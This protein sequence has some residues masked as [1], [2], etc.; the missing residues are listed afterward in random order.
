M[1]KTRFFLFC[2]FLVASL[3]W[4]LVFSLPDNYFHLVACDVGQGDGILA[5]YKDTQVLIDGGPT[6]KILDCLSSHM[7]FWDRKIELVVLTHPEKDHYGG[8]LEVFRRYKVDSFLVSS[9][10]SSSQEYQLLKNQVGSGGVKVIFP[11]EGKFIRL[12]M[13]H[14]VILHPSNQFLA[15]NTLVKEKEN[16][17]QNISV[18]GARTTKIQANEFSIN[19]ILSFGEFDAWLSGDTTPAISDEVKTSLETALPTLEDGLVEYI[20]V[21]HHGSKNGLTQ[22]LLELLKP[23]VAVISVGKN[24]YGHPNP[25]ILNML[26]SFG[27]SVF[28]TDQMGD[29]EVIS[30]GKEWKIKR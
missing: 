26:S 16:D 14:F 3:V 1:S 30:D 4:L 27:V 22:D 28:R 19:L 23:K 15:D 8:L 25:E 6:S 11:D 20:K 21:P 17:N 18:L 12:G 29:V 2:L 7:P 10:D 13:M 9:L 5:Y 24:S